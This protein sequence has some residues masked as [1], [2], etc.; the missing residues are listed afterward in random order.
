VQNCSKATHVV[1]EAKSIVKYISLNLHLVSVSMYYVSFP[2]GSLPVHPIYVTK[3]EV[4]GFDVQPMWVMSARDGCLLHCVQ[5]SAD[6]ARDVSALL[7]EWKTQEHNNTNVGNFKPGSIPI[8]CLV[9]IDKSSLIPDT[10]FMAEHCCR[11]FSK[12]TV[13]STPAEQQR[14]S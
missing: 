4:D 5:Y 6:L 3:G 8:S 2:K 9:A 13:L 12:P 1:C 10:D 11:I 14:S 7:L